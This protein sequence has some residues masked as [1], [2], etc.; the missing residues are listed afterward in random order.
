MGQG[1]QLQQ[2]VRAPADALWCAL[3]QPRGL[4]GWQADRACGQIV[5]GGQVTLAYP[6]LGAE[7]ELDVVAVEPEHRLLFARG[8]MRVEFLV[9]G[10]TVVLRHEGLEPGDELEGSASAWRVSLAILAHY[11]ESHLGKPRQTHWT[12]VRARTTASAAHVFFT[13]AAALGS[14]LGEGSGVGEPSDP[15]QLRLSWG[16]TLTGRVLAK[17]DERDLAISWS[18]KADSV[19][20]LRTLPVPHAPQERMLIGLWSHWGDGPFSEPTRSGLDG[21]FQRLAAVLDRAAYA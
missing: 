3:A 18:E 5:P 4:E 20:V 14:W 9:K 21:A 12:I 15:V 7:I 6:A 2:R 19:L 10:D 8:A 16:E 1:I 17:T 11:L 13:E